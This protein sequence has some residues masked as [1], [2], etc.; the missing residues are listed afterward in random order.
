MIGSLHISVRPEFIL[1]CLLQVFS[2]RLQWLRVLPPIAL[3]AKDVSTS[4]WITLIS[5]LLEPDFNAPYNLACSFFK[6]AA[7]FLQCIFFQEENSNLIINF[8]IRNNQF[9]RFASPQ[10]T[11]EAFRLF[12][13]ETLRYLGYTFR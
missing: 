9:E 3:A 7:A 12:S 6:S 2:Y 13:D 1:S 5:L 8:I 10:F 11:L 4:L